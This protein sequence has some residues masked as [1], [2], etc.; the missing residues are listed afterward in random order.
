MSSASNVEKPLWKEIKNLFCSARTQKK[1]HFF[2]V[3]AGWP[4]IFYSIKGLGLYLLFFHYLES[5]PKYHNSVIRKCYEDRGMKCVI[6]FFAALAILVCV[7]CK[8]SCFCCCWKVS[9]CNH[10]VQIF[11]CFLKNCNSSYWYFLTKV[12]TLLMFPSK[13]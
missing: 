7:F 4:A 1:I 11:W 13:N 8:S 9:C 3:R 5:F 2:L 12:R 6:Y 10:T